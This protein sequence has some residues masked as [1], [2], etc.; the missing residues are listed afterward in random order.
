MNH[1]TQMKHFWYFIPRLWKLPRIFG[2]S[3]LNN[4]HIGV[5]M[6]DFK[7]MISSAVQLVCLHHVKVCIHAVYAN[8]SSE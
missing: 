8:A 2:S 5:R 6:K 4:P 3:E 7:L 1:E